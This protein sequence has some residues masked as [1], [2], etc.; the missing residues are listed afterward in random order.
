MQQLTGVKDMQPSP[1]AEPVRPLPI[2]RWER[3]ILHDTSGTRLSLLSVRVGLDQG[4][5]EW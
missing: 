4:T 1:T 5:P 2:V 3:G